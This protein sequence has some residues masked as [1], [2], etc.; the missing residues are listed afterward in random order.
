MEDFDAL[1]VIARTK[2]K[3]EMDN[4]PTGQKLFPMWG[5]L[6]AVTYLLEFVLW[7]VF[8]GEW[9]L[10]LWI[11]IPLVGLPLM[12]IIIRR[13]HERTHIRT[14][15]SR[16]V[17][18]YWIF[19]AC[20]FGAGGFL[21]GFLGVYEVAEN[22]LICLLIGIGAFI[23]G[24]VIRFRP[25]IVG[26]LAGAG[27]GV[28]SFVLQGDLWLYQ[29]LFIVAVAVVSLIIPGCLFEKSLKHGV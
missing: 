14:H 3:V 23:T 24:E 10:W 18:D 28:V 4:V 16:L 6:T 21:F 15:E 25:M 17:L 29:I 19:A 11:A 22:P 9:C 26:G 2:G 1:D 20:A 8:H 13:D 5:W 7:Q 12:Y 27:L